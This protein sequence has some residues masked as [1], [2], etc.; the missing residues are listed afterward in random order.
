MIQTYFN[1]KFPNP[2][3]LKVKNSNR[4]L[5]YNNIEYIQDILTFIDPTIQTFYFNPKI[6][7]SK[8]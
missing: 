1:L 4:D 7:N 8:L 3:A 2:K 6:F 5:S